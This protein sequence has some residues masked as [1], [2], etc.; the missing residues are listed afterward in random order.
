M[1]TLRV[2]VRLLPEIR[3]VRDQM[4]IMAEQG[5][6]LAT[7]LADYLVR[8]GLAFR[9]AHFVVGQIVQ[10]CSQNKKRLQ[11]CSLEEFKRF[12]KGIDADIYPFLRLVS[13]VDR[14]T[15]IGGTASSRVRQAIEEARQ[16]TVA[17][18]SMLDP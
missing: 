7:D 5:Y 10:Y 11:D 17:K 1:A 3:F 13:A 8:K 2:L 12:H 9:K 4:A 18:R 6:T 14:R 15:S 16:E